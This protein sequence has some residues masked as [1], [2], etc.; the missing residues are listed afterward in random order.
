MTNREKLSQMTNGEL[1][2]YLANNNDCKR[3]VFRN[4]AYNCH[5]KPCAIGI[6][7]WL[8]SEVEQ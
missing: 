7:E 4:D 3:C 1:A 8:D 2:S 6:F 5:E